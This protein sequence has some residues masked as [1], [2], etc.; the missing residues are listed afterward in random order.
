LA[1]M[2]NVQPDGAFQ[3]I[4][5]AGEG[6]SELPNIDYLADFDPEFDEMFLKGQETAVEDSSDRTPRPTNRGE[7]SWFQPPSGKSFF[8]SRMMTKKVK[9]DL[10]KVLKENPETTP[11][12][13]LKEIMKHVQF[14]HKT[15]VIDMTQDLLLPDSLEILK[16][17]V[18]KEEKMLYLYYFVNLYKDK[19]IIIFTNS[20]NSSARIKSLLALAGIV[21][22]N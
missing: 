2:M 13:K 7:P 18:P 8:S 15:K 1:S 11:N 4:K 9:N 21:R 20:I 12:M 22:L 6:N 5:M 14:K 19:S 10:K 16:V 17:D 3:Q